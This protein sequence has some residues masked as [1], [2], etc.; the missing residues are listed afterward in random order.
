MFDSNRMNYAE[1][2]AL[3]N[4]IKP[5]IGN[6]IEYFIHNN[7]QVDLEDGSK[8][9]IDFAI[10]S[11]NN[12][13]AVEI[14]GYNFHAEGVISRSSFDDQL[15]RQNEIIISGWKIIR[16]SFD[17]IKNEPEKCI[18]Q[19]RRIVISDSELHPNFSDI[20]SPTK[21]QIEA[22]DAI[23]KSREKG[24][25]SGLVCLPTGTG[26]TILSALD[27]KNFTG[28]ILF[29]AHTN[30][31]LNQAEKSFKRIYNNNITTGFI[32]SDV[33]EKSFDE[34]IIFANINSIRSENNLK[35][36]SKFDFDYIII[37]EFHHG[38]APS[39]SI[40][41][42]HF[43]PK[44]ILALTATPDR[45]DGKDILKLVQNNLIYSISITSAIERGFL[46]PFTYYGLYDNIDYSKIIH[47]GFRYD[48]T[49][50][51]KTLLIPKRNEAIL[52]NY[53][54]LVGN[55]ITIAFCV[56]IRHAEEMSQYFNENGISSTSIH[57]SLPQIERLQ[58]IKKFEKK[59]VQV[60]FVRD[61][62]NEG[63]DF[64]DTNALLFL[65]P[66]ESKI[67]F[68]QQ[69]GRGLRLSPNKENILILD[70]IGNYKGSSEIPNLINTLAG[71]KIDKDRPLKPQFIYDN[72]CNIFF[73]KEVIEQI[74]LSEFK[75]ENKSEL[76]QEVMSLFYKLER[77]LTPF[78]LYVQFK[79]RF[80]LLISIF[81]GYSNL[82]ERM[83]SINRNSIVVDQS[84]SYKELDDFASDNDYDDTSLIYDVG[85][86]IIQDISQLF[87][88]ISNPKNLN[89]NKKVKNINDSIL[90][91]KRKLSFLCVVSN[92]II[93]NSKNKKK[94][95]NK[96]NINNKNEIV[97]NKTI[98]SFFMHL[99]K[100][101]PLKNS[102]AT[103]NYLKS[104]FVKSKITFDN[105]E[106]NKSDEI[107]SF[108][109]L[110]I[111]YEF[112]NWLNEFSI[113]NKSVADNT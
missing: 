96:N 55:K 69:L 65:R 40:I 67:I 73:T 105:F 113:L 61:I 99:S 22:L 32:N 38:A 103:A 11:Q 70:F 68:L 111:D 74:Q 90:E 54:E 75:V 37:D 66:T 29:I 95:K 2:I 60:V 51:E 21:L 26:K 71:G 27:S 83:N 14:D 57:S 59:E 109:S 31:I 10:I 87:E 17:Q 13:I 110:L 52:A 64:P 112:I 24:F 19:L 33:V 97:I 36:L 45:T 50:L 62:F 106:L 100:N 4:V 48:I 41:F 12:R 49:D 89:N 16:F 28:R 78:D 43:K 81:D 6:K 5:L 58:R 72:G 84:V 20:L 101:S 35:R 93:Y 9:Y 104:F 15:R 79:S 7:Y 80:T 53:K 102:Y 86:D 23:A 76:I 85:L 108:L 18:D 34:N 44:F 42:Q 88:L 1:F 107:Y 39:Y 8:R 92:I 63:V 47:N 98:E 25:T 3:E 77:S 82:A 46:V 30:H 56:S 91:I 94:N